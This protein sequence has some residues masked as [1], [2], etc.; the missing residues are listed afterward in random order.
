VNE[1]RHAE[2]FAS[3]A[4]QAHAARLGTWLFL[5]SELLLFTGLFATHA[6]YRR[7]YAVVFAE[8]SA[9]TDLALMTIGTVV[10][11]TGSLAV[12][13]A[14]GTA[15]R[16]EARSTALW[17]GGGALSAVIFLALKLTEYAHHLAKGEDPGGG[18]G[19]QPAPGH[20]LFWTLYWLTTGLHALHVLIGGVV[21]T[22][23][24][25]A[26]ARGRLPPWR[27]H[28]VENGANYWHLVDVIWLFVWPLFYLLRGG[29]P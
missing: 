23:L 5:V 6:A 8:E 29:R 27:A 24:A 21:L 13:L 7:V 18:S 1:P 10:L 14:V 15:R 9:K 16:G 26:A 2:H 17:L 11:L 28:V 19:V 22:V 3:V 4:Q 12:A 20:A 25:T